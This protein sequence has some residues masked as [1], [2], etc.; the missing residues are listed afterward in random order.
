MLVSGAPP[1][2]GSV[3]ATLSVPFPAVTELMIGA[4]GTVRGVTAELGSDGS[5][6]PMALS[7]RTRNTYAVP[8][9]R[10]LTIAAVVV[11]PVASQSDHVDPPS[12]E[13]LDS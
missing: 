8:F 7:A 5:D 10:P 12:V 1:S 6:A 2:E 9:V 4:S 3:N 11:E 13:R